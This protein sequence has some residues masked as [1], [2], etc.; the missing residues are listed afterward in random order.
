M[1]GME[2]CFKVSRYEIYIDVI[3]IVVIYALNKK[4][5]FLVS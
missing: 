1:I 2:N 3:S 4:I 5:N